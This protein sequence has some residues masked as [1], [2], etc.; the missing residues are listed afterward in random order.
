MKT[1][2]VEMEALA[3]QEDERTGEQS[4]VFLFLENNSHS[5]KIFPKNLEK[6]IDNPRNQEYYIDSPRDTE[7]KNGGQRNG[8][9]NAELPAVDDE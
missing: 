5:L 7:I 6:S 2:A 4:P 9:E 1:Q 8:T 3:V